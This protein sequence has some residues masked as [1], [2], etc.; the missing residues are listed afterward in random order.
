MNTSEVAEKT[1]SL[2]EYRARTALAKSEASPTQAVKEADTPTAKVEESVATEEPKEE[3]EEESQEESAEES[4]DD[5]E[6]ES[7]GKKEK[8]DRF[9]KRITQLTQKRKE[10]EAL[11]DANSRKVAELE[12]MIKRMAKGGNTQTEEKPKPNR[13]EYQSDDEYVEA[14]TDW[15]LDQKMAE[16]EKKQAEERA[17]AEEEAVL[18][19]Y[20]RKAKEASLKLS[21]FNEVMAEFQKV[22]VKKFI[23]DAL[24]ESDV[25]PYVAY[26]LAKD[27]DEFERIS[28]LPAIKAVKELGKL[29]E[30][31]KDAFDDEPEK[32]PEP[33]KKPVV[34]TKKLE[35]SKAFAPVTPLKG[36]TQETA[37]ANESFAA[38]KAR[39]ARERGL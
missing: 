5:A 22:Q 23:E 18:K 8:Q 17:K 14:L 33:K 10:A 21:D 35:V 3:T 15:K 19:S 24:L 38:Y 26:I 12:E 30:K 27:P 4:K 13:A 29:E 34:A 9:Q 11:A 32:E 36:A 37:P 20:Q 1:E 6:A 25:G 28:N 2:A 16:K 31:F 7:K 39:I